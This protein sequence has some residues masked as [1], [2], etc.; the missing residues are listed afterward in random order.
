MQT[1][2]LEYFVAVAEELSFTRASRR[3][4]VSQSALSQQIKALEAETG[5][6]L[7]DRDNHH[8]VLTAAGTAFLEDARV[9]LTYASDALRRVRS[10]DDVPSS[11]LSVGYIKGYER[12]NLTDMLC[13]FHGHY[14]NVRLSFMR[15]NVAE[16]YDALGEERIDVAV[17]ILYDPSAMGDLEY[18][19]LRR[20]PL[21]AAVSAGHPLAHR[22]EID[23]AELAGYPLVDIDKGSQSYGEREVIGSTF[24]KAGLDPEVAYVSDDVETSLLAVAVGLGY[25]LL[26]KYFTMG[27]TQGDKVVALPIRKH[28][29]EMTIAAAW[30]PSHKSE[31]LDLFLDEYLSVDDLQ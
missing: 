12:T 8:V 18:Q 4:F 30:L 11:T 2:Q 25:A 21:M 6:R 1:K 26:P 9:I 24:R 20:W 15:D 16:L 3:F 23:L 14:P 22:K 13:A 5:R 7:F 31:A 27:L 10:I 29:H 19:P 28:E 17:N